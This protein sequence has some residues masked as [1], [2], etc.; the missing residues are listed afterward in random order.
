[1]LISLIL[2]ITN[3]Y[4]QEEK[5]NLED[6]SHQ[7]SLLLNPFIQIEATEAI[8]A[9]YNFEFEKAYNHFNYLQKKYPWHPLPY[10]L[11]G[12]NFWWQIVPNPMNKI[13]DNNF[14]AYMDTTIYLANRIKENYN[15]IEGAFFL[16]IAYAFEGRLYA[17][18]REY[19]KA[20]IAGA[21]ALKYLKVCKGH[22]TY[23]IELLFGTG[24][25]N[26]YAEWI[27]EE[28]PLLRPLMIFFSK[29]D[30]KKG[31][32]QLK[33]VASLSFYSRTEAQ[34]YL[35]QILAIEKKDIESAIQISAYLNK[36]FPN[37]AYFHRYYTR[38]LYQAG[39]YSKMEKV[40]NEMLLRVENM[41]VGY[42]ANSGRYACF[43]L[44]HWNE[45]R[46]NYALAKKYY[47][48]GL[49]FSEKANAT[50]KGYY[51]YSLLHLGIIAEKEGN[52]NLAKIH[53]KQV[54]KKAKRSHSTHKAARNRLKKL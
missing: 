41:Q 53:Y 12:L 48:K 3:L 54:K 10:L 23:S 7:Y 49:V 26:Y 17:D 42:E 50:T 39:Q 44:G 33:K 2:L 38:V 30:K 20:T 22:E 47:E 29:G 32:Q 21:Q 16:A 43:Y 27:R 19:R 28:Y 1:M 9:M 8:N 15:K 40:A 11:K 45:L 31:I 24:L 5:E 34:Y 46:K 13:W 37:N 25:F 36:E 52:I 18:R 51:F 4:A 6:S 35:M 14:L